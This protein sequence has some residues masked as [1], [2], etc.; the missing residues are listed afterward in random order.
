MLDSLKDMYISYPFMPVAD[1][2][3]WYKNVK[4]IRCVVAMEA[5]N[6]ISQYRNGNYLR[7]WLVKENGH[8]GIA[9]RCDQHAYEDI[10]EVPVYV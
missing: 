2:P 6:S 10:I 9:V 8:L 3:D 1:P 7:A 5:S 4:D